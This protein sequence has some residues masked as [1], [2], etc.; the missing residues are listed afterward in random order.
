MTNKGL[1]DVTAETTTDQGEDYIGAGKM[2]IVVNIGTNEYIVDTCTFTNCL[3]GAIGIELSNGGKASVINSQFTGCQANGDGGAIYALIQSG[4]I[5]TIDGQCRFTECTT[6]RS[7][8]GIYTQINGDNSKLVIGNGVI[9]D[10]CS[11]FGGGGLFTFI[12]NGAQLIFEGDCQFKDC[13]TSD[14]SGGIYAWCEKEGSLIQCLGELLFDNCSSSSVAGGAFLYSQ[15]KASIELNKVTC[16]DCESG[17]GA[18]LN[19]QPDSNAHFTI[20]GKA[21]FTRCESTGFGGGIRFSIQGENIEI[22]LTG[23]MEFIDCIGSYGGGISFLASQKLILII[24]C[25]CTFQNCASSNGGGMHM[26]LS[27]IDSDIQITGL[28]SFDNCSCTDQGGEEL[29]FDNC[30]AQGGGGIYALINGENSQLIIGHGVIF[31]TCSSNGGGGFSVNIINGA[32]LIFEGNFQFLDCSADSGSGGGLNAYC[33]NEGSLIQYLGEILFDNCSSMY[34]GGGAF[35]SSQG[36]ASIELNKV[37]CIDCI[38]NNQGGGLHISLGLNSY[39]AITGQTSFTRCESTGYGGG[40]RFS[41]QGENEIHLNGEMEF[42]DC[43]GSYGGGI[44]IGSQDNNIL[45]ISKA[46]TFQNCTGSQGGGMYL[47]LSGIDSDIQITGELSFDNCSCTQSGGGLYLYSNRLQLTFENII[48]CKDCSSQQIGGGL[49]ASC[50]DEGIVRFVRQLDF[51]NCS[52]IQQGGGLNVQCSTEGIIHFIGLLNFDNCSSRSGGGLIAFCSNEGMIQFLEELN[53][54]NCSAIN[55]AGGLYM[56]IFQG[57]S[58]T[59]DNKI[60]FNK[61]ICKEGNGGAMYLSINFELQSSFQLNDIIIQECKALINTESI[62]YS[63]SGFGGGIFIIGTG[64]Y[65]VSS[66]MLDFSK[67][68]M[69]GNTADKAGQ[70][71]YVAMPNVIEWCRTGTSGEYVKGN[72]SDIDS[73]ESELEGIPVGY[74]NFNGLSQV[75]IIKDQRPLELWWRTI[76]HILN[77]NEGTIKGIDQPGCAEYNNP[78]YSI[79]YAIEQISVELGGISTSIIPEKRIAEIKIIKGGDASNIN[80]APFIIFT[81]NPPP[82]LLE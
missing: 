5:L 70:S 7:G 45:V 79:D 60:E 29:N 27:D 14:S 6:Q 74:S 55:Q 76:W 72:Y 31:D 57:G 54:D 4:G 17:Y 33:Y 37:T 82:P 13:S 47:R 65:D 75:D 42:I 46:C 8:G 56:S 50:M 59:L 38:G 49:F 67:M 69:Y 64:V 66:K 12:S 52:A 34:S 28:L 71:L 15:N 24:S 36:K 73:D 43:I 58:V 18:G 30:S 3:S 77:R 9:F 32:Q 23:E 44:S 22:Q 63:Q 39:F 51:E 53:F 68:K 62:I 19:V 2:S 61:C 21:S 26:Y 81:L 25:S 48:Y 11:S 1:I 41:I 40:I 78:C 16:V 35:I 20:S 10:T 80:Q